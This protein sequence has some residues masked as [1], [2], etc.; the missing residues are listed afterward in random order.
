MADTYLAIAQIADD[1]IIR[2]RM[3]AAVTQQVHLGNTPQIGNTPDNDPLTW[4]GR[5]RYVWASSPGWGEAWAY[6]RLVHESDS[7]Y[8]PGRDEGVIT[9]GMILAAIQELGSR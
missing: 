6:A 8:S 3:N 2:S 1:E 9:D 7:D 4:V 5:N